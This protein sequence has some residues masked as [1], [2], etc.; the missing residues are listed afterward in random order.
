MLSCTQVELP[1]EK[2]E[3]HVDLALVACCPCN[4]AAWLLLSYFGSA[5]CC[6]SHMLPLWLSNFMADDLLKESTIELWQ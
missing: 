6:I 2:R 4:I 3:P 1:I 5:M